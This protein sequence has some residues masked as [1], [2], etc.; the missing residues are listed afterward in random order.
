M[1]KSIYTKRLISGVSALCLSVALISSIPAYAMTPDKSTDA[2]NKILTAQATDKMT[3]AQMHAMSAQKKLDE[4]QIKSCK[5]HEANIRRIASHAAQQGQTQLAVFDKISMRT[6]DFA[7]DKKLTVPNYTQLLNDVKTKRAAVVAAIQ[8]LR[9]TPAFT[10][11]K[12]AMSAG[13]TLKMNIK[14]MRDAL[15][16]YRTSIKNLIVAVHQA[17]SAQK[18]GA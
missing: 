2:A 17:A 7:T 14:A 12:D 1:S 8:K 16:D 15:K 10:C 18:Q 5:A 11:D 3:D 9:S 13:D 6:Q 4:G